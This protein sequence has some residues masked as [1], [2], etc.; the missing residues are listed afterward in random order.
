ML[1]HHMRTI[2]T[3]SICLLA[4]A[5][6]SSQDEIKQSSYE[7]SMMPHVGTLIGGKGSKKSLLS[8]GYGIEIGYKKPMGKK[9]EFQAGF[10][11]LKTTL[12][13]RFN[14]FRWPDDQ[15]N[16]MWIPWK[17]HEQYEA[18]F[19]TLGLTLGTNVKLGNE[20]NYW[21]INGLASA[22]KIINPLDKVIIN[23][24]GQFTVH[25]VIATT[26]A[27]TQFIISSGISY[28]FSIGAKNNQMSIGPLIDYSLTS[29]LTEKR[30][31]LIWSYEGG[32]P[33]IIHFKITYSL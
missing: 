8:V 30:A 33:V 28:N 6:S 4:V 3:F 2:L 7:I 20:Q 13:Q 9:L 5:M 29:L 22:R 18:R 32:K 15:E 25:D 23:E 17:S 21:A 19:Y 16:G 11:F 26:I 1:L 31:L 14:N 24:S 10:N 12:K 27:E